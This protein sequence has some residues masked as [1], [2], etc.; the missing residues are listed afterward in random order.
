ML[1]ALGCSY[2]VNWQAFSWGSWT[3]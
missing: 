1:N 3:C 2:L